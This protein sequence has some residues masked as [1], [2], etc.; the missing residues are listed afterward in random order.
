MN[1]TV[2]TTS[3]PFPQVVVSWFSSHHGATL[4]YREIIR[5][6]NAITMRPGLGL[7]PPRLWHKGATL[8]P[9]DIALD[10]WE[11][12]GKPATAE[13]D[14]GGPARWRVRPNV[15]WVACLD[16]PGA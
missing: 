9:V 14:L 11:A 3:K 5:A 12:D 13:Y 15:G 10:R 4:T 7:T 6:P 1:V 16:K 2:D 8:N